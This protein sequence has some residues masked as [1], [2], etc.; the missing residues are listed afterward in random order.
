MLF[1]GVL[2]PVYGQLAPDPRE[3][4]NAVVLQSA[5]HRAL[6]GL[7]LMDAAGFL[8]GHLSFRPASGA[9]HVEALPHLV[10]AGWNH[11]ALLEQIPERRL[12]HRML[13][14]AP[15]LVWQQGQEASVIS[16]ECQTRCRRVPCTGAVPIPG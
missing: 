5:V 3:P 10:P 9:N 1:D 7:A 4:G 15:L 12:E 8:G 16:G 6:A 11:L 13:G 14:R 2:E